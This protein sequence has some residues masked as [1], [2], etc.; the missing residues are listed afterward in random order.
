MKFANI[1]KEMFKILAAKPVDCL[2]ANTHFNCHTKHP[3]ILRDE[4]MLK[5]QD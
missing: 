1:W 5:L 2:Q 4:L 3:H